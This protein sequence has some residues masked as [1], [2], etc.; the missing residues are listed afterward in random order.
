[1]KTQYISY[2]ISLN[3]HQE[4][5]LCLEKSSLKIVRKSVVTS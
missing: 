1:M 5:F 3:T 2:L 4:Y